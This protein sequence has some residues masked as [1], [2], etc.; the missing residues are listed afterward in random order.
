VI[1]HHL[2]QVKR[3]TPGQIFDAFS[4]AVDFDHIKAWSSPPPTDLK[5]FVERDYCLTK[6]RES[7]DGAYIDAHCSVFTARSLLQLLRDLLQLKFFCFRVERFY[8]AARGTAEMSLILRPFNQ[9]A[10]QEHA[11]A[12]A[13]I[14][15]ILSRGIDSEGLQLDT[16][17]EAN[18][19][20][21][22]TALRRAL[23]D[24]RS[25]TS[26]KIMAPFAPQ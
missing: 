6:A 4:N 26:W 19:D 17:E 3:P 14:E 21:E 1:D 11:A 24:I 2:R 18:E 20:P 10:E 15:S 13:S 9:N 23:A 7:Q 8:I 25:S 5:H 12:R 22:L 16:I